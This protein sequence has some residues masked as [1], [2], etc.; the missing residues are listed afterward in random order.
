MRGGDSFRALHFIVPIGS[1]PLHSLCGHIDTFTHLHCPLPL[2]SYH[3]LTFSYHHLTLL[4]HHSGNEEAQAW[5][6]PIESLTWGRGRGGEH[7][8]RATPG[9]AIQAN[10]SH[11]LFWRGGRGVGCD[12]RRKKWFHGLKSPIEVAVTLSF[13]GNQAAD[14]R[15]GAEQKMIPGE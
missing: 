6:N 1:S 8:K 12:K 10:I 5:S 3:H 2:L 7:R 15:G 14:T 13:G 11:L 9:N 4:Y